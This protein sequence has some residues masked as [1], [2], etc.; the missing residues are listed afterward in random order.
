[1]NTTPSL[2]DQILALV[3]Q[4]ISLEVAARKVLDGE[5]PA[6]QSTAL[7]D[8]SLDAEISTAMYR[9][10]SP[11]LELA[12]DNSDDTAVA[13]PSVTIDAITH[14]RVHALAKSRGR[15][16]HQTTRD[17]VRSGLRHTNLKGNT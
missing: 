1:M 13:L 12:S 15:T 17:L 2:N 10:D 9:G 3:H 16:V 8:T 14:H 7:T 6:R 11:P 4:G 5:S